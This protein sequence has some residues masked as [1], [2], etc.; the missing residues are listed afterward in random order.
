[1]GSSP[2]SDRQETMEKPVEGLKSQTPAMHVGPVDLHI[3]SMARADASVGLAPAGPR[4][5][6]LPPVR[7]QSIAAHWIDSRVGDG[8]L[9]PGNRVPGHGRTPASPRVRVATTYGTITDASD[10][11]VVTVLPSR[12]QSGKKPGAVAVRAATFATV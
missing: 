6:P 9:R 8:G 2:L 11:G 7:G 1:L 12:P 10:N 5:D 4:I 3:A